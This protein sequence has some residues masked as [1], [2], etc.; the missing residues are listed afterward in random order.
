MPEAIR[1]DLLSPKL[2]ENPYPVYDRLR[3]EAPVLRVLVG[4][5]PMWLIT[6]YEHAVAMLKDGRLLKTRGESAANGSSAGAQQ[7][8]IERFFKHFILNMDP[9]AHT[10]LRAMGTRAFTPHFV[11][12]LRMRVQTIADDLLDAALGRGEMDLI[13]D[14]AEKLSLSVVMEMLGVPAGPRRGVVERLFRAVAALSRPLSDDAGRQ[15]APLIN[16]FLVYMRSH[17]E[18]RRK[19]PAN[20]LISALARVEGEGGRFTEDELTAMAILLVIAGHD[21]TA[22][23]IGNGALALLQHPDQ[24]ARLREDPS[25]LRPAIEEIL[26]YDGPAEMTPPRYASEDV[27]LGGVVIPKGETVCAVLTAAN[28]DPAQFSEPNRLDIAREGNK[29]IAFGVGPH[30]C[31]GAHLARLEGQSAL[32]TLFRRLP[33]LRRR[34]DARPLAWHPL[35]LV[36][37]LKELP[38][39]F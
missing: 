17:I 6:S 38:V 9:P 26:R 10:R 22:S 25:R 2:K 5:S 15:I 14:Y 30:Y 36:R 29:H 3:S 8:P 35:L 31:F 34:D 7:R 27:E 32:D 1:I 12:N 28:R 11:E 4:A 39:V 18:Q 33:G 16:A 24:R 21:T 20:D 19:D 13:R 37:G 23:L